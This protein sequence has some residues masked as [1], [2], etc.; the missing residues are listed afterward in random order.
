VLD[1]WEQ[2]LCPEIE[3]A[4][5][6]SDWNARVKGFSKIASEIGKANEDMI[7][8]CDLILGYSAD[9]N[10]IQERSVK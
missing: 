9:R 3:E 7:R 5:S 6:M 8:S 10:C 4:T 2:P 1:P